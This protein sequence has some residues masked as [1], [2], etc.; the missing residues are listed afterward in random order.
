MTKGGKLAV[1]A[2]RAAAIVTLV[3]SDVCGDKLDVI[4]S[5]PTLPC[6]TSAADAWQIL[7]KYQILENDVTA[8]PQS[9]RKILEQQLKEQP[10]NEEPSPTNCQHALIVGNNRTACQAALAHCTQLNYLPIVIST[11]VHGNV[12]TVAKA[13]VELACAIYA[14]RWQH[15]DPAQWQ[16]E[17]SPICRQLDI[18]VATQQQLRKLVEAARS[19]EQR[20]ICLIFG[21]EPTVRL[22]SRP[23]R[24]GRSQELALRVSQLLHGLEANAIGERVM[25]LCAG[26]DGFDGPNAAAGAIGCASVARNADATELQA[27]VDGSDSFGWYEACANGDWH[28]RTGHTGTNVMDLHLLLVG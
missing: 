28:I 26:T 18:D 5:G 2:R 21:G 11:Q 9:I 1:A 16:R 27:C 7:T 17:F 10:M 22:A 6:R 13:Y 4:A 24:G 20:E 12:A 15:S 14:Y 25:V 3:I 19:E 23:G 8:C